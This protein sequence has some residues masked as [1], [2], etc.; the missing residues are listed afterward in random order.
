MDCMQLVSGGGPVCYALVLPDGLDGVARRSSSAY[1]QSLNSEHVLMLKQLL[2]LCTTGHRHNL[3]I[4][5]QLLR[6]KGACLG[7]G[8]R[9]SKRISTS[10][11]LHW[12]LIQLI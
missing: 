2:D 6:V 9:S 10:C 5:W 12:L 4:K 11:R 3:L 1:R 7:V 8:H